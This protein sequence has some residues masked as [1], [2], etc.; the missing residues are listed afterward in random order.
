MGLGL[1]A[2]CCA[3]AVAVFLYRAQQKRG[4]WEQTQLAA[5]FSGDVTALDNLRV[6]GDRAVKLTE[7]FLQGL[8]R[9]DPDEALRGLVKFSNDENNHRRIGMARL[10]LLSEDASDLLGAYVER[11]TNS[12]VKE[13]LRHLASN[14]PKLQKLIAGFLTGL[15]SEHFNRLFISRRAVLERNCQDMP[16]QLFFAYA[17]FEQAWTML[18]TSPRDTQLRFLL[19]RL[20]TER[21][22]SA[23][24][25]LEQFDAESVQRVAAQTWWPV[26]IEARAKDGAYEWTTRAARTEGNTALNLLRFSIRPSSKPGAP[27]EWLHF[28]RWW[29]WTY[30]FRY[31]PSIL[32]AD[33]MVYAESEVRKQ[34]QSWRHNPNQYREKPETKFWL[35]SFPSTN[36]F[37]AGR[38]S[39]VRG[40]PTTA[41]LPV[42]VLSKEEEHKWRG[43]MICEWARP[44]LPE[45]MH[46]HVNF[47]ASSFPPPK[48]FT[49]AEEAARDGTKKPR[50][51]RR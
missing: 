43:R 38:C 36:L 34:N 42:V 44:L 11:T 18:K 29:R 15:Y 25:H 51:K 8:C 7:D 6:T 24:E 1:I 14:R 21:D 20:Y 27:A 46:S 23:L 3:G 17:P 33:A 41:R 37:G 4:E 22:A 10:A 32:N 49:S 35:P 2:L 40:I 45:P 28:D 12:V 30:L 39:A 48:V 16:T 5:A 26:E 19:L 50:R 47:T 31:Q 13:R 9:V